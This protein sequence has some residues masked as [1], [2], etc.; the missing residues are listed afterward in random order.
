MWIALI[1]AVGFFLLAQLMIPTQKAKAGTFD[2]FDFPRIDDGSPVY[3]IAGRVKVDSANLLWYGDF[4]SKPIKKKSGLFK[5]S[6]V[7]YK[8]FLGFQLGICLGPGVKLL[9]VWFGQEE[10]GYVNTGGNTGGSFT[11]KDEDAFGGE[12]GGGGYDLQCT[13]YSGSSTQTADPYLQEHLDLVPGWRGLAYLVMHGYIGNSTNLQAVSVEVERVPDPLGLGPK[14]LIGTEGDVNP[15]NVIYEMLT[16][17]F[18]ALGINPVRLNVASFVNAGNIFFDEDEGISVGFGGSTGKIADAFA[19]ILRQVDATMYDDPVDGQVYLKLLRP[20][21]EVSELPVLDASSIMEVA[22]YAINLWGDTKNKVRVTYTDRS[23]NYKNDAVAVAE[24]MANIAFQGNEVKPSTSEYPH[25]KRSAH[26]ARKATRDLAILSTPIANIRLTSLRFEMG[27]RPGSPVKMSYGEY[28]IEQLILRVKSVNLGDL[29]NNRLVIELTSDKHARSLT[30][31]GVPGPSLFE[32]P[33]LSAQSITVAKTLEAPIWFVRAQD[34]IIDEEAPRVMA[35]PKRPSGT[36]QAYRLYAKVAGEAAYEE[37]DSE[38]AYPEHGTLYASYPLSYDYDDTVG[39]ELA[40]LDEPD[41]LVEATVTQ[42]TQQ[43]INLILVD[44]EIMAFETFETNGSGRYV[45]KGVHRALLDTVPAAHTAGAKVV[46]LT[47][48]NVG[49]REFAV[50]DDVSVV[51]AS[52][53]PRGSQN[54]TTGVTMSVP[55]EL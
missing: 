40:T 53:A 10:P 44:D 35:L 42:I 29:T 34:D 27:L 14:A 24:D 9:R 4:S 37:I 45:L 38:V 47:A 12:T 30:I 11:M 7:G 31:Y 43:G 39:L 3:Y 49:T 36:Q 32:R 41:V 22:S 26:A 18:G 6:T 1:V 15:A 46:W 54:E 55:G 19:D 50:G 28:E 20:D 21:Y 8:Y 52:I 13:Y 25:V 33:I 51:L 2:D 17:N 48:D 5:K 16:N 23:R